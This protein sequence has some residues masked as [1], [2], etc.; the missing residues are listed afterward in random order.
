MKTAELLLHPVRLR[1]V[2]AFLGGGELTTTDLRRRLDDVPT[3]TVY[4]QVTTLL[5]GDVLQVVDERKVR[6]AVERTYVLRSANVRVGAEEAAAM[7]VEDHRRSFLTF[8]A[9]LMGDFERYL[10]RGDVDLARDLVGYGQVGL[11][12]TDEEMQEFLADLQA[13]VLPRLANQ[14]GPGRTRR[15]FTTVLL[16]ASD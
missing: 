2:Q 7:S 14:P 11:Q 8:A 6:G 9:A 5:E 13:V 4:R 15:L 1:I 12:L 10:D 16:P 3:A